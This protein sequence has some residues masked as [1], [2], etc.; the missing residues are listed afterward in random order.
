VLC[1][2]CASSDPLTLEHAWPDWAIAYVRQGTDGHHMITSERYGQIHAQWKGP[3]PE[4]TVRILCDTCN[5]KRLEG[6]EAEA[7]P[8]LKRLIACEQML[9]LRPQVALIARWTVKTAMVFEF[10]AGSERDPFYTPEERKALAMERRVP[11]KTTVLLAR[12]GGPTRLMFDHARDLVL[13]PIDRGD[14]YDAFV[15]TVSIG[16]FVGQAITHR[17]PMRESAQMLKTGSH[18][19]KQIWPTVPNLYWPP[20]FYLDDEGLVTFARGGD[21]TPDQGPPNQTAF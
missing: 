6:I 9:V 2:F 1:E 12:Y 3:A 18:I 7:A 21:S 5:T 13:N 10:T 15:S 11:D 14:P 20:S 19:A 4:I 16:P 17:A 8:I